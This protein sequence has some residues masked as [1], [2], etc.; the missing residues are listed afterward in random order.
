MEEGPLAFLSHTHA[1]DVIT[2]QLD[3]G[4]HSRG[5]R[6]KLDLRTFEGAS[7]LVRNIYDEGIAVAD[8]FVIVVS[9]ESVKAPWVREELD[10]ATI[11][12]VNRKTKIIPFVID[13]VP[14]RDIFKPVEHLVWVR[15]SEYP[16]VDSAAHYISDIIHGTVKLPEVGPTPPWSEELFFANVF[17]LRSDDEAIIMFLCQIS[18][19]DAEQFGYI[20]QYEYRRIGAEKGIA[21]A[22]LAT[23]LRALEDQYHLIDCTRGLGG[24]DFPAYV[25]ISDLAIERFMKGYEPDRY[26]AIFCRLV[27]AIVNQGISGS[28]SL[29]PE[30]LKES[31]RVRAILREL[32]NAG[33]LKL[34]SGGGSDRWMAN[35]TLSRILEERCP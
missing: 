13:D 15:L 10:Y 16:S 18:L 5:V 28:H 23:S 27:S 22:T 19:D 2:G 1:D 32:N 31:G 35:P 34:R 29:P 14:A 17:G 33:Y 4:L 11:Q 12:R 6:T 7:K 20:T 21:D 25:Q 3:E 8:A 9:H 30:L 26:K 24:G